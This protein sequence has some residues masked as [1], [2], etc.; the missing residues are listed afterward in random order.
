[1]IVKLS[2]HRNT[3][4]RDSVITGAQ[5][6]AA[7]ALL[8]WTVQKLS[9]ESRVSLPTLH[10]LEQHDAVPPVRERTLVDV[11]R[12]LEEAGVEFI[13]SPDDKPG[14]RFKSVRS[15]M[16]RPSPKEL[17]LPNA[18]LTLVIRNAPAT[19]AQKP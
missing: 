18:E 15:W 10:R 7:R 6:R 1:M 12:A 4:N 3:V 19:E 11:K 8:R 2:K 14:V 17:N 16:V 5:V 13:G 9:E